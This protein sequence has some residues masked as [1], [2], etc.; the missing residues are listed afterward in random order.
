M[1]S[2]SFIIGDGSGESFGTDPLQV[3]VTITEV[4][5]DLQFTL[6]VV[7]G[8]VADLRGFFFNVANDD[9]LGTLS[10]TGT[11]VNGLLVQDTNGDGIP[12]IDKA[13]PPP[14][15]ADI[16][17]RKFEAGLE[18]GTPGIGSGDDIQS[19]TF[20]IH[21][22][23]RALNL[24]DIVDQQIGIRAQAVWLDA[25]HDG[26]VDLDERGGSSKLGG[27]VPSTF[28]ISGTKFEDLTG[29][30]KSGDDVAWAH[31]PVTIYVDTND[32]GVLDGQEKSTTTGVN[33]SWTIGG[34]TLDDVGKHIRG[35]V[36]TASELT[37]LRVPVQT[38]ENPN[39]GGVDTGHDFTN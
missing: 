32:N 23:L 39:S 25:D 14:P 28:S 22:D 38:V 35:A 19:T 3:Q 11:N 10:V 16:N 21:S 1:A 30:G 20:K 27:A 13:A 29:N 36:P 8:Y 37:Q 4:G 6:Q 12:D 24:A 18:L 31:D 33:G 34:L 5:G 17:P 2:T 7:S 26:V 15:E 9:V